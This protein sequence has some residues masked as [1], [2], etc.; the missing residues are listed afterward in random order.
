VT[1][2]QGL[3]AIDS[4]FHPASTCQRRMSRDKRITVRHRQRRAASSRSRSRSRAM[5]PWIASHGASG[6]ETNDDR[7]NFRVFLADA[8]LCSLQTRVS[9]GRDAFHR[10][11]KA[12]PPVLR[13]LR[14]CA[15]VQRHL[16]IACVRHRCFRSKQLPEQPQK[17]PSGGPAGCIPYLGGRS[18]AGAISK[19]RYEEPAKGSTYRA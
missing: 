18:T 14:A 5:H 2:E 13:T 4:L 6:F 1:V 19:N 3:D 7:V 11:T 8:P 17:R 15:V 10:H 16:F 12:S 9:P